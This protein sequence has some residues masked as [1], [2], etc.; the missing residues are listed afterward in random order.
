MRI[1]K[2]THAPF[3][4]PELVNDARLAAV[5]N[6]KR[7]CVYDIG[8]SDQADIN[9]LFG[10]GYFPSH[11]NNSVRFGWRY[12]KEMDAIEILAYWYAKKKRQHAS[13]CFVKLESCYL[14]ILNI[15]NNGHILS[16]YDGSV[17]IGH[18]VISDVKG[19]MGY[20]LR[21]YFGGNQKAPHDMDIE[22]DWL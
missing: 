19:G 14:Y 17:Q 3:R 15:V 11:H 12:V 18:Y 7:N 4:L 5:V 8:I 16:V 21:P 22:I 1:K 10:I 2:G 20:L 9:K 13:L 6:F